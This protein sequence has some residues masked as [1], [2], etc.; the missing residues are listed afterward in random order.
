MVTR[1]GEQARMVAVDRNESEVAVELRVRRAHR[2]DEV[3]RVAS[4]DEVGDHLGV[5]LRGEPRALGDQRPLEVGVVLDDAVEDD[6]DGLVVARRQRV[7]VRLAHP[8]VSRP[9]GMADAGRGPRADTVGLQPEVLELADGLDRV[10]ALM[11]DEADP[12]RVVPAVL[13][14]LQTTQKPLLGCPSTHVSDYSA[15][16]HPRP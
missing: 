1:A 2:L 3:A 10:E 9:A 5:G 11:L 6:C 4:L 14:P 8:A 12:G 15:H 7:G 16:F 13:E